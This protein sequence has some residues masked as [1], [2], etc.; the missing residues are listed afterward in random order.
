MRTLAALSLICCLA[1]SLPAVVLAEPTTHLPPPP[2]AALT[3]EVSRSVLSAADCARFVEII[4][5][6]DRVS[7]ATLENLAFLEEIQTEIVA[8]AAYQDYLNQELSE[9]ESLRL[10]SEL[11]R[12]SKVLETLS[13]IMKKIADTSDAL[14]QNMK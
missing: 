3:C 13:N 5:H 2:T 10:Q 6:M 1:L 7:A 12:R 11:E 14:V 8:S 4:R 9:A